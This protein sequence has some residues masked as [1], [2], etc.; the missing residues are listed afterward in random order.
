MA[1]D[2]QKIIGRVAERYGVLLG[3]DD[4]AFYALYLYEAV[5]EETAAHL[6]EERHAWEHELLTQVRAE[7]AANRNAGPAAVTAASAALI[8]DVRK[9]TET[10]RI[11]CQRVMLVA[12]LCLAGSIITLAGTTAFWLTR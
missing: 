1:L 9:E 7:V 12:I 8:R 11:A 6:E 2:A 3:P 4:P 5:L 10:V